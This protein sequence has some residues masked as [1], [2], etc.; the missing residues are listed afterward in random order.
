MPGFP[1]PE[2][3]KVYLKL[4]SIFDKDLFKVGSLTP[5]L[6]VGDCASPPKLT[7]GENPL[8][9]LPLWV[10]LIISIGYRRLILLVL[11]PSV[12]RLA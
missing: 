11:G 8:L 5:I 12:D 4:P 10:F 9:A 6:A 3:L 2:L 7:F 1:I